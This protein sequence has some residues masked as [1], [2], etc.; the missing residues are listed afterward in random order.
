MISAAPPCCAT[1]CA[2]L[3]ASAMPW[4]QGG[5][6]QVKSPQLRMRRKPQ[7]HCHLRDMSGCAQTQ[8]Q[9]G[10]APGDITRFIPA[11]RPP[12]PAAAAARRAAAGA[13]GAAAARVQQAWPQVPA[14]CAGAAVNRGRRHPPAART[15]RALRAGQGRRLW[16]G[17]SGSSVPHTRELYVAGSSLAPHAPCMLLPPPARRTQGAHAS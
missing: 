9:G 17:S 12:A 15:S 3:S 14:P 4:W 8:T 16:R 5:N 2:K 11:G 10:S 6:G 7:H 13:G 1:R